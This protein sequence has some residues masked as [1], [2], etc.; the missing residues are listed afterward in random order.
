[1]HYEGARISKTDLSRLQSDT[2]QKARGG[3]LQKKS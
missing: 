2:P 3:G 1:M